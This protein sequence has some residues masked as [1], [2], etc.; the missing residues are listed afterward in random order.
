MNKSGIIAGM[1]TGLVFTV[2]MIC[3]MCSTKIFVPAQPILNDFLGINAQGVGVVEMI[4][5]L[6]IS[7]VV[8]RL[9][10]SK[11]HKKPTESGNLK[12]I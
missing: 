2:S 1:L 9:T 10:S 11:S 6:S 5:N 12:D 7:L 3:M 4:L 8:S